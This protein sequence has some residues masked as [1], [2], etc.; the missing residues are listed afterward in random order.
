V[1]TYQITVNDR[2]YTIEVDD[3]TRSPT[4]V[5][6]NGKPFQVMISEERTT[7]QTARS[8]EPDIE[9]EESYVP[10]VTTTYVEMP[11]E[12]DVEPA[13][14]GAP[15]PTLGEA[16]EQVIA[17]MPG[18]IMDI[19]VQPG[20]PIKQGDILCN[21][22]AMK[23]KSPIRASTDGTIAQVL[24]AEGQNVNYGDILFTLG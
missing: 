5:R 1:R 15:A 13:Q 12:T 17:P 10:A 6:V 11:T 20:D 7:V 9:F 18:K 21:L 2:T 8:L 24:I 19:M 22:E 4:T 3:I 23:M 14:Q 16:I